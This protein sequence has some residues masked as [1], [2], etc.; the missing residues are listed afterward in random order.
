M[1][2]DIKGLLCIKNKVFCEECSSSVC[3]VRKIMKLPEKGVWTKRGVKK[4]CLC[5][6]ES[7][8]SS[9]CYVRK[10]MKPPEKG[11]SKGAW[12]RSVFEW[13]NQ[14]SSGFYVRKVMKPCEKGLWKRACK[15][16]VFA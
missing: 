4:E 11:V 15:G 10:V 2:G 7:N 12:K 16:D 9:R 3:D 14:T 13:L 5:I 1:A 6:T 8:H